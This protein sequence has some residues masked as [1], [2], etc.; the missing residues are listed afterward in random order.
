MEVVFNS[1][2]CLGD[3]NDLSAPSDTASLNPVA[4][5]FVNAEAWW[6]VVE[7]QSS[8]RTCQAYKRQPRQSLPITTVVWKFSDLHHLPLLTLHDSTFLLLS[9]PPKNTPHRDKTTTTAFASLLSRTTG[10]IESSEMEPLP[11]LSPPLPTR[12]PQ[13]HAPQQ[14]SRKRSP[15]AFTA[16]AIFLLSSSLPTSASTALKSSRGTRRIGSQP[17]FLHAPQ[18]PSSPTSFASSVSSSSSFPP[19]YHAP[20]PLAATPLPRN[21]KDKKTKG[22]GSTGPIKSRSGLTG[23]GL[24]RE[25]AVLGAVGGSLGVWGIFTAARNLQSA[26]DKASSR[27]FVWK[28]P[29]KIAKKKLEGGGLSGPG[30]SLTPQGVFS[31][32]FVTYLARFLLNFDSSVANWWA[33]EVLPTAPVSSS[34]GNEEIREGGSEGVREVRRGRRKGGRKGGRI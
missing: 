8:L 25:K 15:L 18:P 16:A 4:R 27:A 21:D 20:R 3:Q 2:W 9:T 14:H 33:S 26:A 30:L 13:H 5:N 7:W 11:S 1:T 32:A 6:S 28:E 23:T 12:R 31:L 22:G 34:K 17:A 10:T 24:T 29:S 19:Y